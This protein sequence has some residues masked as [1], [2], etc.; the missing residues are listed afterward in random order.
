MYKVCIPPL[1]FA[2]PVLVFF[3]FVI[4]L[5]IQLQAFFLL[6]K[7]GLKILRIHKVG[8]QI[9]PNMPPTLLI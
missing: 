2:I 8:S 3:G 9:P 7:N 1:G 6:R 5:H 4:Q